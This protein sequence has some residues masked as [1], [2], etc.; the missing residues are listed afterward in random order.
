MVPGCRPRGLG[1]SWQAGG[2]A[3]PPGWEA[4]RRLRLAVWK[5]RPSGWMLGCTVGAECLLLGQE[6]S[7]EARLGVGSHLGCVVFC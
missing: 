3:G 5:A 6:G 2:G 4:G 1:T 7:G